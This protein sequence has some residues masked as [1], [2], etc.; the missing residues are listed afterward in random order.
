MGNEFTTS[1]GHFNIFPIEA[2]ARV[3]NKQLKKW[4]PIFDEIFATP[5]VKIAILNH[6]RD[7]HSGVR[8]FGPERFNATVGENFAGW[9]MRFNAMEI[10]NSGAVQTNPLQ[11]TH[12]WMALLN[13][14][15]QVTP[16]GSSDSHDVSRY[17]VGQGRTYV[18]CDD[19]DVSQLSVD[20]AIT[21]LLAGRVVVSY[22][23][24]VD[25]GINGI[26]KPGD[27]AAIDGDE[28]AIN[29]KVLGPHWTTAEK[30]Q[31]YCNGRLIREEQIKPPPDR[32]MTPGLQWQ[33]TWKLPRLKHDVHLVAVALGKGIEGPYWATAKPYQPTS[34][35]F[36]STAFSV[37]GALWI[38]GDGDGKRSSAHHYAV[39]LHKAAEGDLSAL[40]KSLGKYDYAVA[41]Q[42]MHLQL[43]E[44]NKLEHEAF[45]RALAGAP[46]QVAEG[47]R[48]AWK[49]WRE[50]EL[51]RAKH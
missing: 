14:G 43:S 27:L 1:V 19:R 44:G 8:P 37:S 16:V 6:A 22:G 21:N 26:H 51:A 45:D 3:P 46:A 17:I 15:Y 41:A 9:P 18:R 31:L 23:L 11:L 10:I 24:L 39:H 2:G 20:E 4:G 5:G 35:D 40:I 32:T 13:R 29:L 38:D 34:E 33:G 36:T 30:V 42:A 50:Q 25:L 12:D 47:A 28:I 7:L 48:G 49:A